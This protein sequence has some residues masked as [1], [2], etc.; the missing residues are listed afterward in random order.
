MLHP[1]LPPKRIGGRFEASVLGRPAE[2]VGW[3]EGGHGDG[4]RQDAVF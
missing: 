4:A 3:Q 1:Q 2:D